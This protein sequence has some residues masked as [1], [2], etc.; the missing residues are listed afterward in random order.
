V[1]VATIPKETLMG[2]MTAS[3]QRAFQPAELSQAVLELLARA[4]QVHHLPAGPLRLSPELH[5]RAWWWLAEGRLAM[6]DWG[7]NGHLIETR[8]VSAGQ[9]FDV[10]SAWSGS[11]WIEEA[12][13]CTPVELWALPLDAMAIASRSDAQLIHAMGAV[14]SAQVRWLTECKRDITTKDVCSRVAQWLLSQAPAGAS[15]PVVVKLTEQ[16][17][18]IARQLATTAESMSRSLRR[19]VREG[20]IDMHGYD[21][22]LRDMPGLQA[23]A[24][25]QRAAR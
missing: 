8:V 20:L 7:T 23:L 17:R 18:S 22:V 1:A 11:G 12:V 16:K 25:C 21:L 10:A 19:M 3:L 15:G 2:S 9:W 4:V 24:R 13:C 6:G 14:V 5:G